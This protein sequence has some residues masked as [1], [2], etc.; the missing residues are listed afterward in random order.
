M[1]FEKLTLD[2]FLT[3][4]H[5]EFDLSNRG[6]LLIQGV[7][8]DDSSASSNGA[9]KSSCVDGLCWVLFGATARDESGDD[10]INETAGKNC[11]GTLL[12]DDD[13]VRYRV[14]RNRKNGPK[15]NQLFIH[16]LDLAGEV[17]MSKGTE[18]ETQ[19]VVNK[20]VGCSL[21]VF[22]ASVYAGQ[23]KMPDLPGMTDKQLK[24][25][26]EEAAGVEVLSAAHKLALAKQ[27]T[28]KNA[29]ESANLQLNNAR[30]NLA[31]AQQ[32]HSDARLAHKDHADGRLGRAK[33]KMAEAGPHLE[34]VKAWEAELA[35]FDEDA[36]MALRD[37]GAKEL[38]EIQP[39]LDKQKELDAACGTISG[40][41]AGLSG[42]IQANK[43]TL[44]A[45]KNELDNMQALVGTPCGSCGKEYCEHD[46]AAAVTTKKTSFNEL[47]AQTRDLIAQQASKQAELDAAT[48]SAD[49]HRAGIPDV[50]KANDKKERGRILLTAISGLRTKIS[51]AKTAIEGIKADAQA[52]IKDTTNPY[53]AIL[54]KGKAD[55]EAAVS[56]QATCE[57][58]L[59]AAQEGLDLAQDLV[60]V[61]GP[62]GVRA[63]ILD[64]VTPFLNERTREY[65]GALSDGNIHAT[66]STLTKNAKGELKEKFQIVVENDK[67]SKR[68]KGQ[69]GGEK[70]KVRLACALALQDMVASRATKPLNIF[71]GDEIDHALD[72]PGLERLMGVLERKA[73][74]RGT[75][76]VISHNSL[77]DWIDQV[78][79]V[80]KSAGQSAVTGDNVKRGA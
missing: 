23:E 14:E 39:M 2:N 72:E 3:V 38:C 48:T 18:K 33:L 56:A 51:N 12:L 4:G 55:E 77:G 27:L 13:G 79:T 5:A 43:R 74:D 24:L 7:N 37:E 49:A 67:G 60:A 50:S 31:D 17:D 32:R 46:L 62:A 58:G 10:V 9:G 75:V 16:R 76:L 73:R 71:I 53:D 42:H 44:T 69:S 15:K 78:I 19:E 35:K 54:A 41:I 68:F 29:L 45:K 64:T 47:A 28:A 22:S 59:L 40:T 63:H 66:W 8:M 30:N 25:L 52:I 20:V 36:A 6:L 11:Q 34:D 1:N 70:R 80:T 65:L 57:V 21:D 61:Y 26:I